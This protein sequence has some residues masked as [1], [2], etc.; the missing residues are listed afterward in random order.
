MRKGACIEA[1]ASK[2]Q[3][4]FN[5]SSQKSHNVQRCFQVTCM[6]AAF[7]PAHVPAVHC[8]TLAPP[9]S[10]SPASGTAPTRPAAG[11]DPSRTPRCAQGPDAKQ[12]PLSRGVQERIHRPTW[13]GINLHQTFGLHLPKIRLLNT[14]VLQERQDVMC[15]PRVSRPTPAR[16]D[17]HVCVWVCSGAALSGPGRP[18]ALLTAATAARCSVAVAAPCWCTC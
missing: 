6:A 11:Y 16:C 5:D 12:V 4:L 14:R 8:P 9:S 7:P 3:Q 10:P 2:S 17:A 13:I 1:R 15:C 18:A